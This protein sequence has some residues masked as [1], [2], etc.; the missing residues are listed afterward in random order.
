MSIRLLQ[1]TDLHLFVDPETRLRGVPTSS[2]FELVL[3]HL[4]ESAADPDLVIVTGDIAHDEIEPTYRRFRE[5]VEHWSDRLLLLPGNHDERAAMR[6]VFPEQF[7]A[8]DPLPDSIVFSRSIGG[9][10]LIGLDTH[11][12]GEVAGE[13]DAT[14]YAWLQQELE[15]NSGRPTIVF[16]HHPPMS[17]GC[18]WLDKLALLNPLPLEDL[19]RSHDQVRLIAGG[20]VHQEFN[21]HFA[22]RPFVTTPATSMQ[23]KPGA[24]TPEYDRLPPGYRWIELLDSGELTSHVVRLEQ[25]TYP[26]DRDGR[27]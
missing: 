5:Y 7:P 2:C 14:Q 15:R 9:W 13:I 1:L 27:E 22:G 6:A 4:S 10:Q 12:P 26:P 18:R 16:L 3:A 17:I 20:H 19:M 8:H 21:D 25:L 23:F 11:V 24:E